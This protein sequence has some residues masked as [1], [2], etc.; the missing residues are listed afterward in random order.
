MIDMIKKRMEDLKETLT[1]D[2]FKQ[3]VSGDRATVKRLLKKKHVP[4]Q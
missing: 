3:F 2:E 1:E 4:V